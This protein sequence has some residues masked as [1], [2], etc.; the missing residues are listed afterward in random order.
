V[1]FLLDLLAPKVGVFVTELGQQTHCAF[2]LSSFIFLL[3]FVYMH[4]VGTL[5]GTSAFCISDVETS[6]KTS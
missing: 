3:L 1:D 5:N 4:D 6:H 2:L